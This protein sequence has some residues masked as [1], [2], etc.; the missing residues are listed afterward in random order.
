MVIQGHAGNSLWTYGFSFIY[1]K[2][3]DALI[4]RRF[5]ILQWL[6]TNLIKLLTPL[7]EFLHVKIWSMYVNVVSFSWEV[8]DYSSPV[9][10]LDF[11]SGFKS[12]GI[13]P[14]FGIVMLLA[15]KVLDL[16]LKSHTMDSVLGS[17]PCETVQ[18]NF[19]TEYVEQF[20]YVL[21]NYHWCYASESYINY[22]EE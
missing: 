11:V 15:L 12:T 21:G 22:C 20:F 3:S 17:L 7:R 16:S 9:S 2:I 19:E 6:M 18:Y 14:T 13:D 10:L 1:R 4:L 8:C 5:V